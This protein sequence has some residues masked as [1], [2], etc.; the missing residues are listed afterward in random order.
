[1]LKTVKVRTYELGLYFRDSEFKGLLGAGRE[2]RPPKL[3]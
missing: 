3:N 2:A 1:M